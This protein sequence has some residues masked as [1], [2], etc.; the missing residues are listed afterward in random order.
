MINDPRFHRYAS[1]QELLQ[2]LGVHIT[3]TLAEGIRRN[4]KASL[5]VSGGSTP[6]P[7][8]QELSAIDIAW[9]AVTVCLV[10]ER[11]VPPDSNDSNEKLARTYL[12][13]NHAAKASFI[14][15]KNQ[16]T[17]AVA[18]CKQCQEELDTISRPFDLLILGLGSDGHTASLFPGAPELPTATDMHSGKICTAVT[19][20]TAPHERMT[21]TLPA[22]L[23]SR[24]LILHITGKKKKEVLE[25]AL[26]EG[27]EEKLPIRYIL[28]QDITP[29]DIYWTQ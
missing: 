9:K 23:N 28:N 26:R 11:W 22:I 20:Q 14:G 18:G 29:L 17:T 3:D 7:L 19:P 21:L 16:A 5:A 4:G 25:K 10:D 27:P 13:Q 8:F 24:R 1:P 12:L 2:E 15:M 6:V